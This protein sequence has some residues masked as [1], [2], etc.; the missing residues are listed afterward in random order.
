MLSRAELKQRKAA[1]N[2]THKRIK[3]LSS[4]VNEFENEVLEQMTQTEVQFTT[5]FDHY[6]NKSSEELT[7]TESDTGKRKPKSK[8]R[9]NKF[10]HLSKTILQV[11]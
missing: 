3:R 8:K 2:A 9:K 1:I 5:N 11:N 10:S 4:D 7:S 6:E